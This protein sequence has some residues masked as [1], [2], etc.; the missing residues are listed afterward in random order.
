MDKAKG[1][2]TTKDDDK[3]LAPSRLRQ[4]AHGGGGGGDDDDDDWAAAATT[5]QGQVEAARHRGDFGR[6]RGINCRRWCWGRGKPMTMVEPRR[7]EW[8]PVCV[9]MHLRLVVEA[10][11]VVGV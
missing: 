9:S 7:C 2:T 11:V 5:R 6:G 4:C 1:D 3:A 8:R 10:T